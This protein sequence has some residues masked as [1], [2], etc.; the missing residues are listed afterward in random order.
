MGPLFES[1]AAYRRSRYNERRSLLEKLNNK[2][3]PEEEEDKRLALKYE[4]LSESLAR[5]TEKIKRYGEQRQDQEPYADFRNKLADLRETV[6][7]P[8]H[9]YSTYS[10]YMP[11]FQSS[12]HLENPAVKEF[13]SEIRSFKGMLLS[14]RNFPMVNTNRPASSTTTTTTT[15]TRDVPY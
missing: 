2:L 1:I 11:P 4:N 9:I 12:S 7:Q 6:S 13:K 14:R 5:L 3:L 15:A 8:D 10:S